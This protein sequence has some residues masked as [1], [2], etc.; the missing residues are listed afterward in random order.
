MC[1]RCPCSLSHWHAEL[2][3]SIR[4][5][6]G[7][8]ICW[9]CIASIIFGY[10]FWLEICSIKSGMEILPLGRKDA[11]DWDTGFSRIWLSF[12]TPPTPPRNKREQEMFIA[13]FKVRRVFSMFGINL[14]LH[15][16]Y[17]FLVKLKQKLTS[18]VIYCKTFFV[19]FLFVKIM[20]LCV[21]MWARK[22]FVVK[23]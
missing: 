3:P 15:F 22:L 5:A 1:L 17:S 19:L 7:S 12:L 16:V 13:Y 4:S 11:W 23:F 2:I 14:L 21:C 20:K 6:D 8:M 18:L 10:I 9:H